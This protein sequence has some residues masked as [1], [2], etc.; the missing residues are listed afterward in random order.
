[1]FFAGNFATYPPGGGGGLRGVY[2]LFPGKYFIFAVK[3]TEGFRGSA[4]RS[5]GMF[6]EKKIGK[7]SMWH[8]SE[9]EGKSPK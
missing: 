3:K 6:L 9:L 8:S 7:E 5:G 1:M 2:T 4:S